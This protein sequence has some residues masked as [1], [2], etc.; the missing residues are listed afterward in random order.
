MSAADD[1]AVREAVATRR[2]NEEAAGDLNR[3]LA[4]QR[5]QLEQ[6]QLALAK[7]SAKLSFRLV[8]GQD[9]G[10]QVGAFD[11][12]AGG[13]VG[14][15]GAAGIVAHV[16]QAQ[17]Q[18]VELLP[19]LRADLVANLPRVL[20]RRDDAGADGIGVGAVE[21]RHLRQR[22]RTERDPRRQYQAV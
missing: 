14:A 4:S 22:H 19:H 12:C 10:E 2:Q 17:E 9:A 20:P 21:E 1:D 7:A 6:M 5:E 16:P 3:Q 11:D 18:R 13:I 15:R 8:A